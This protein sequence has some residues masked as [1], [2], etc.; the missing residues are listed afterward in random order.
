MESIFEDAF[1]KALK[2]HASIQKLVKKKVDLILENPI[3]F[4][5]PLKAN[6]QGFYSCPVKR[7]FIIIYLYCEACRKKGDDTVVLCCDCAET[8]NR[9]VKFVLLGPHYDAYGI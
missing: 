6:W 4:G 1:L 7:S 5:E 8:P 2:K 3:A 9:T